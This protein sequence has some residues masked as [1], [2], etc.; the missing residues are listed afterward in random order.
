MRWLAPGRDRRVAHR[1]AVVLL[2]LVGFASGAAAQT[3]DNEFEPLNF[4]FAAYVGSGIY[5]GGDQTVWLFRIPI[6]IPILPSE[7]RRF[8][9]RLRIRA[10]FGFYDFDP[11]GLA[12]IAIPDSVGTFSLLAGVDVPIRIRDNWTLGPFL[13][14]GPAWDSE[15]QTWSGVIGIGAMSRAEFPLKSEQRFVLWNELVRASNFGRDEFEEEGFGKFL[16]DLEY[17]IPL[18]WT[19]GGKRMAV[20]PF[21]KATWLFD[22]LEIGGIIDNEKTIRA[23]YEVG[24]KIG[25]ENRERVWRIPVPRLGLSYRFGQGV[26]SVRFIFSWRY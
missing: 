18:H 7:D 9:V 12:T 21:V 17:R 8:G 3:R 26:S 11:S 25:A 13:D 4:A 1:A 2:T 5:S 23:R 15:T 16:T 14:G 6:T 10:T 22:A 24:F 19:V 20:G